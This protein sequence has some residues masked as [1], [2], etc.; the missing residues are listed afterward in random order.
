MAARDFNFLFKREHPIQTLAEE[1]DRRAIQALLTT[2]ESKI[3]AL[4]A[5]L[6]TEDGFK[7]V[8][9]AMSEPVRQMLRGSPPPVPQKPPPPEP[10]SPAVALSDDWDGWPLGRPEE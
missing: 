2:P 1:E 8:A 3:R 9:E 7:K 6:G 4:Q 5:L 10:L